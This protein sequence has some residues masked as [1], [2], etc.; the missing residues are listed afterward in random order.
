MTGTVERPL[1][2]ENGAS[3]RFY[4]S[5][6]A[7]DWLC[8]RCKTGGVNVVRKQKGC[9][10][11]AAMSMTLVGCGSAPDNAAVQRSSPNQPQTTPMS[12]AG[13]V[14]AARMAVL[15]G[16][17]KSLQGHVDAMSKGI[18]HDARIPDPTRPMPHE[19]ARTQVAQISGVRS[20]TWIDHY[21]LLVLVGGAQ[22][23]DMAMV[24]HICDA[25]V[26]LGETL[27]VVVSV[28]DVTATI[29]KGA[30]AVSRD[31][32]LPEGQRAF[33]QQHRQIEALDPAIR[34]AFE[35]QQTY[36]GR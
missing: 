35:A 26:P 31:C 25:L 11:L 12:V 28:Q 2:D 7:L 15:T 14:A 5:T 10:A 9:A 13:H 24:D 23:R 20:A 3:D 4:P 19:A 21:N 16:D 1:P 27:G 22:Y 33:L 6:F 34:S 18:L 32:Q 17:Q 29:S 8:F 36:N 30:D